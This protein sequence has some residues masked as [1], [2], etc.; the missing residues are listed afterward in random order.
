MEWPVPVETRDLVATYKGVDANGRSEK[1]SRC[2]EHRGATQRK[3]KTSTARQEHREGERE[4][5][6]AWW[7]SNSP[8]T[9]PV[10]HLAEK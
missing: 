1:V 10:G 7:D 6:K 4:S 9:R 8:E 3:Q 5:C 2:S